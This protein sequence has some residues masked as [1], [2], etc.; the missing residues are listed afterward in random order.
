MP[1]QRT[2]LLLIGVLVIALALVA[3]Q[4]EVPPAPVPPTATFVPPTPTP[5][6]PT[7]T[8]V[9]PTP[10]PEPAAT[11]APLSAEAILQGAFDASEQASSYR[12]DMNL[13]MVLSGADIGEDTEMP[14][15]LVGDV[16]PP[17]TVQGTLTMS[18]NGVEVETQVVRVAGTTY[19]KNP[20]TDKWLIE[21]QTTTIF[22][23]EDLVA[24]PTT[25]DELELLGEETV[26]GTPAYHLTGRTRLP[27]SF[28]EPLG[29]VE[30][31][32]LVNYWISQEDLRVVRSTAE[33]DIDFTGQIDATATVSMTMRVFDYDVPMEIVIPE[34]AA[35]NSISVPEVGPIAIEATLLA[36]LEN[37][38]PEGHVQRG[39]AS[40]ADGRQGLAIAHFNQALAQ[41]PG[42][43]DALLYRGATLAI[44]GDLDAVFADLDQAIETEPARADAYALRAWAH[45]R[46]LFRDE[47]EAGTAI[48]L[49]R[50]DVAKALKIE[51]DLS[52]ALAIGAVADVMEALDAYESNPKQAAEDFEAGMANLEAAMQQ[53]PDAAAGSYLTM[54]QTLAQL[55]MEDRG[56]LFQQV[57]E[58]TTQL[59]QNPEDYAAYGVRALFKLF[60]G[61]QPTPNVQTLQEAGD[62]LLSSMALVHQ[63]LPDLADPA[64]GPLQVARIWDLQEA[65]YA[66]GTLYSQVFFNQDPKLF[67]QFTQMLISYSELKDNFAEIVDDPIVFGVAFSPDGSQIA[68][69]S[70]SAQL[71]A[72]LGRRHGRKNA[73]G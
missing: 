10:T 33:G 21:P 30:T 11:P 53:D 50:K 6:L 69:L 27:F 29:D 28:D 12:F 26:E 19:V 45:M 73:R 15:H 23:P 24:D 70:E 40:L 3:C 1:T 39:L 14:M 66:N 20:L 71:L 18:V 5:V 56:W 68:T 36:P 2:R 8:P 58:A 25:V 42:W 57:D 47:D 60:L 4:E 62:D 7:P 65:S 51:P 34:I 63:H 44:G 54:L 31:D 13:L 46:T 64:G 16:Q 37:D 32:M 61:S 22:N 49:A 35:T 9:P 17:D 41:K 59:E 72:P 67:P 48:S 38:T 52:A 43:T 55:K